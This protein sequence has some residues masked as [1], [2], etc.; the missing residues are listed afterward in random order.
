MTNQSILK[1]FRLSVK[2]ELEA[3]EEILAWFAEIIQDY[4]PP[5]TLRECKL[6]LAEAFTNT[7]IYSHQ[8][9]PSSVPIILEVNLFSNYLEMKIWD[10]G[11]PFDLLN[12]LWEIEESIDDLE[13]I[14]VANRRNCLIMRKKL[15]N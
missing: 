5:K 2:T 12:K 11:P 13:Y 15:I 14:R 6:A 1:E 9:L 4:L 10:I 7:V 8:N 3:L